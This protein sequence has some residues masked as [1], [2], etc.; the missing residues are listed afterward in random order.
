MFF[1]THNA[2]FFRQTKNWFRHFKN[3]NKRP[4]LRPGRFFMLT[5]DLN[6]G[7]RTSSLMPLDPLLNKF[8]SDYHYLFSEIFKESE[9]ADSRGLVSRYGLPNSARRLLEAFLAFRVP[10]ISGEL[11][12]KLEACD[13]DHVKKSRIIRFLHTFSHGDAVTEPEHDL[14]VLSAAPSILKDVLDLIQHEDPRHY[15]EMLKAIAPVTEVA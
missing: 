13:F 10:G 11:H 5:L 2:N 14:S 15:T 7:S 8:E 1:L 6:D 4:D 9:R 12:N 3:Q